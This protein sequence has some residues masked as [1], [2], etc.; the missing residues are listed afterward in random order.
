MQILHVLREEKPFPYEPAREICEKQTHLSVVFLTP[1]YVYKIKKPRDVGFCDYT[2][3]EQRRHCCLQEVRLNTSLAP[4]VYLGVAPILQCSPE[5]F[6]L[7]PALTEDQLPEAG[8]RYQEGTVVDF[9]V[10]MRRLP[11][12]ATLASLVQ[13]DQAGPELMYE[14]ARTIAHFHMTTP[15]NAF[16][17]T[18]GRKRTIQQNWEE[19]FRQIYPYIGRVIAQEAYDVLRRYAAQFLRTQGPVFARRI[20]QKHIRDCHGDLRLQ[21]VYVLPDANQVTAARRILLLDRIE[22]SERFRYGDVASEVAFLVMEL[23]MAQRY[24]LAAAFLRAYLAETRDPDLSTLLPFYTCYRACVRAKVT[25]LLLDEAEIGSEQKQQ[26]DKEAKELFSLAVR[27]VKSG[28]GQLSLLCIGGLMGS[29]K[30]TLAHALQQR[31]SWPLFSSD[32]VRKQIAQRQSIPPQAPSYEEGI[33]TPSWSQK[34]YEALGKRALSC[35]ELG[36]SVILDASFSRR[37]AR[38]LLACEA[39]RY[40]A[41]TIFIECICP[42]EIALS[43]LG[44]RWARHFEGASQELPP[45][46]VLASDGRPALYARQAAHWEAFEPTAETRVTHIPLTTT[47]PPAVVVQQLVTALQREGILCGLF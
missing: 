36:Q 33:Y 32:V 42:P 24:D 30:S 26:A 5:R 28:V 45:E 41:R 39:E 38:Q 29:G 25:A 40:G 34:T 47:S 20:A 9:A 12:D 35:L 18:F 44:S 11:E 1:Q 15:T 7:G 16:I 46:A 37:E 21:H 43:R 14:V 10:V 22:F 6:R 2:T 17:A 19:N 4:G 27:T 31:L 23:E 8:A 13:A 3:P